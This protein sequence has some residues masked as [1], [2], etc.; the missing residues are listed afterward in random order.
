LSEERGT[1]HG[2]GKSTLW[3][4]LLNK[5]PN[6]IGLI[7][8]DDYFKKKELIPQYNGFNNWD[9]PEALHL[10]QLYQDLLH[11]QQGKSVWIDTK[12]ELLNPKFKETKK[13][14][15]VEFSPKPIMLVEGYLVLHDSKIRKLF[16]TSIWLDIDQTKSWERRTHFKKDGYLEK[17]MLPMNEKFVKPS[18]QYAEHIID[19]TDM[20]K[21]IVFEQVE[22]ILGLEIPE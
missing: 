17:V 21:E 12:N 8:L 16:E 9:H 18:K 13:H 20:K 6:Q 7:Q 19:V 1:F 11:F 22:N 5:Y 4:S 2:A 14:I 10:D 3:T 15:S